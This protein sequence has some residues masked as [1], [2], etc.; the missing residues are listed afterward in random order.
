MKKISSL[1]LVLVLLMTSTIT[2]GT[3]AEKLANH[4]ADSVINRSFVAYYFPYLAKEN[5]SRFNPNSYISE[6]DFTLSVA[7]L[8]KDYNY[9][10]S[11]SGAT[12]NLSRNDMIDSLGSKLVEIGLKIDKD[13]DIPFKDT[14]TMSSDSIELLRLLNNHGIILGDPDMSFSPDRNLSQVEAIIIL[15]R[16]KEV[17]EKM[18]TVAF[19]TLGIV[20]S[21]NNQEEIII[22]EESNKVLVTIT[23]QFPTP[24]YS[25]SVNRIKKDRDGYRVYFN[26]TPPKEDSIQLQVITYKTLTMEIDKNLLNG[27]PYNFILDGYNA[28]ANS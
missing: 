3:I 21:F 8:F 23:K 11:G 17:L 20:Q 7:S 2:H 15:Q 4:W 5:F 6:Q 1:L 13:I 28:I 18:N 26:I 10:V 22:K 9:D 14:N 16:S 24:G 27:Q 12:G 19:K 25:M